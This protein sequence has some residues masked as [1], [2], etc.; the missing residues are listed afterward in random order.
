[1]P[2]CG[3]CRNVGRAG[4]RKRHQNVTQFNLD[5]GVLLRQAQPTPNTASMRFAGSR[6]SF[7]KTCQ[8]GAPAR[9]AGVTTTA[10][11]AMTMSSLHLGRRGNRGRRPTHNPDRRLG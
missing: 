7:I 4:K 2:Y 11:F 8:A 10:C 1:M 6:R 5:G 9:S 3:R